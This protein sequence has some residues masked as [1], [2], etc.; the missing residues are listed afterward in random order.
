MSISKSIPLARSLQHLTS[1][2]TSN[3]LV[4]ALAENLR[5]RFTNIEKCH[6]LVIV[7]LLDPRFKKVAFT[8]ATAAQTGEQWIIPEMAAY[9]DTVQRDGHASEEP[10]APIVTE[11]N[12]RD[13]GGL[14]D[15]IDRGAAKVSMQPRQIVAAAQ[16]KAE[17]AQF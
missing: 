4:K 2:D 6:L 17:V 8:D 12:D 11:E 16:R 3:P 15:L 14:W 10:A 7:T 1:Q 13:D 5:G 9:S